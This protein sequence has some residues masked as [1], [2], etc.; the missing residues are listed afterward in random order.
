[1]HQSEKAGLAVSRNQR[2][3]AQLHSTILIDDIGFNAMASPG[4]VL[5]IY[6]AGQSVG[7][8]IINNNRKNQRLLSAL[9]VLG[10][11]LSKDFT[12]LRGSH[13][14]IVSRHYHFT[15]AGFE[16]YRD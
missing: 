16:T 11:G 2:P 12:S 10:T 5:S 13:H 15:K 14:I 4:V 3:L 9:G 7:G 1:M 8:L 6:P